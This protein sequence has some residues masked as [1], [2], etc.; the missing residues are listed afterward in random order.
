MRRSWILV[1]G[2]AV[3]AAATAV[4]VVA[5]P[6]AA[7]SPAP[8]LG[9]S[10]ER[11]YFVM[12]DRFIDG[13]PSNNTG[14]LTGDRSVTGYDPTDY[15]FYHGGDLAGL[16]Q[17]LDYI[18]GLGT[19]A[20]WMTPVFANK[21]V[22]GEG[23]D[24]SAGYHGYWTV[25]YTRIDPHLGTNEEMRALVDAAH[26]RGMKVYFDIVVNHT[27]DVITS[28]DGPLYVSKDEQ[29]YLDADGQ[30]FD[31]RDFA[32]QDDFPALNE[33]SFPLRPVVPPGERDV[34]KP[35]WLNDPTMYH[36]RGDSSFDGE[37]SQYGDFFGLDDLFTERPEVVSGMT[38]IAESWIKGMGIDGYRLD[39][40]KHVNTEFWQAFAPA[41]MA[42]AKANGRPDF[43]MFGEVYDSS[44]ALLSEYTTTAD[45]PSVL[46][47]GF[48]Q[49]ARGFASGGATDDL[50]D[51]FDQDDLYTDADSDA[52]S[53]VTFLGNH[54]MGRIG[55]FLRA[56]LPE[57][58]TDDELLQRD[59][60]AH[61][62]LYLVRGNPTVYYGDE[63][64]FS[65]GTI[66]L[67]TGSL[68]D[69]DA[70][71]DMGP[72]KVESYADN[73]LIG[74]DDTTA[75]DNARP[76]A[77]AHPIAVHLK[78]LAALLDANPGLRYGTQIHRL[79]SADAGVYAFSRVDL[80]T[81]QEYVVALNNATTEQTVTIPT[82]SP[83]QTF[84]RI[85]PAGGGSSEADGSGAVAVTVPAL[86]A[87][88]LKAD[89]TVPDDAPSS[90]S[91][92]PIPTLAPQQA[93]LIEAQVQGGSL[94]QVVFE[95]RPAGSDDPWT[96]MGVDD[97]APYRVYWSARDFAPGSQLEI[98]ATARANPGAD[99][100]S[101]LL[102]VG[103]GGSAG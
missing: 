43:L 36:N 78:A 21:P 83:G 38:E 95:A 85:F 99:G 40:A 34:K 79:S 5:R 100:V 15:G 86:T 73:D 82:S 14:G 56:D 93:N 7:A 31:D 84:D 12:P 42:Y 35:A 96:L 41:V 52:T 3:L 72:T 69:K 92:A 76:E 1:G 10:G 30:P 44:P 55:S 71:E 70:R 87:L 58:V 81:R 32:G 6:D 98:R 26:A 13:D 46:D 49:A 101:A 103:V 11:I 60:L 66:E 33:K 25:D 90:V 88:V 64:G 94:A 9:T 80:G 28:P 89:G 61:S 74:T 75:D 77:L 37:S 2:A 102:Q 62:L 50:R 17:R 59:L 4:A 68:G 22:Q 19:T 24:Q 20:I 97:A 29:P 48:Q 23:F 47:F 16:T 63:Q 53:L 8:R 18:Q 65:A 91:L 39:T 27:A 67:L 45:L 51:L 54:D 57:D